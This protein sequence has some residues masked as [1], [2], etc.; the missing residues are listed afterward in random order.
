[1]IEHA[2]YVYSRT[3][4]GSRLRLY[5]LNGL[6]YAFSLYQ[7]PDLTPLVRLVDIIREETDLTAD[8]L[9]AVRD[10]VRG[11]PKLTNPS[12][13]D[14]GIYH[15]HG[16]GIGCSCS[17]NTKNMRLRVEESPAF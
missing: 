12:A 11:G 7:E 3:L 13:A 2:T 1:M 10:Q 8:F 9:T 14:G 6:L 16:E 4:S 17:L 5:T 15:I